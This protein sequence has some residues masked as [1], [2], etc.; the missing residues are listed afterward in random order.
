MTI[1]FKTVLCTEITLPLTRRLKPKQVWRDARTVDE[2][3]FPSEAGKAT[4]RR[5]VAEG[6]SLISWPDGTRAAVRGPRGLTRA[7]GLAIYTAA[8]NAFEA[9]ARALLRATAGRG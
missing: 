2:S 1:E 9:N 3:C 5:M 6:Y 8:R 7:E 4:Y